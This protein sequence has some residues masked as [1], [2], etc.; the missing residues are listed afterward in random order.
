MRRIWRFL[1]LLAVSCGLPASSFAQTTLVTGQVKDLNGVPYAGATMKAGLV[2]AGT[3]VSNP[4]VTISVLSQCR[5]NGFG[6]AP[7]QVP[8]APTNGPFTLDGSGNIPGGGITLQ[9]NTLVT[10][11]GTQWSFTVNTPG[12]PPPLGNGPQTCLLTASV[13]GASQ[14]LSPSFNTCPSLALTNVEIGPGIPV[15]VI[16]SSCTPPG[17]VFLT[18]NSPPNS[19]GYYD[20]ANGVYV[21]RA[22]LPP[23]PSFSR[24][25][26]P[27]MVNVGAGATIAEAFPVN[28][29]AGNLLV[30]FCHPFFGGT[31]NS[32][33]DTAGNTWLSS[34]VSSNGLYLFYVP[35]AKAG[36]NTVTCNM[37]NSGNFANL[38][39]A[40]YAGT[41]VSGV[42]LDTTS[43]GATTGGSTTATPPALF[44]RSGELLL[45]FFTTTGASVAF[46]NFTGGFTQEQSRPQDS[47]GDN[48]A[49]V[50]GSNVATATLA[51]S[52]AW[53][54]NMWAFVPAQQV[55]QGALSYVRVAS[56]S[57]KSTVS[58]VVIT[59]NNG[60]TAGDSIFIL[61]PQFL[62][63]G[64]NKVTSV[65]DTAGNT[66]TLIDSR[67]LT[68]GNIVGWSAVYAA[69]NVIGTN[70]ANS[71]SIAFA[72]LSD[73]LEAYGVEFSGAY[74]LDSVTHANN[75][76]TNTL[77]Y[78]VTA[79]NGGE[80]LL[81]RTTYSS[82]NFSTYNSTGQSVL[83]IGGPA[84]EL[85]ASFGTSALGSNTITVST[86]EV[87]YNLGADSITLALIPSGAT[88]NNLGPVVSNGVPCTN[89]ELALSAGWQSTGSA[90]VTAAAGNGQ[91]CSWTITTGTTTAANPT[92]TDTLTNPLPNSTTVCWLNIYGG[93][94]TAVAGESLRQTTLSATAPIFTANFTPT[95]GGT[96]YFVTRGCG[97]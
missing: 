53:A 25:Q 96:T 7:C 34:G 79:Q 55:Q 8:F 80:L 49:S 62:T 23:A 47:W 84:S 89:A 90:T 52:N 17:T 16:P 65:T 88:P 26:T 36:A 15:T 21:A 63:P 1:F 54:A 64:S 97:P 10:P 31:A 58:P 4:T 2:F 42:V 41:A 3:P 13:S 83:P 78:P 45:E 75:A 37:T 32:V 56:S 22:K 18:V 48:L 85:V 5:A 57:V 20:C 61:I 69:T 60:N 38:A 59:F 33:T 19:I 39:I 68:T 87:G 9:D 29:T 70:S 71:V 77:T 14:S 82:V 93:T 50:Q 94:H 40:E 72:G 76:T 86:N 73:A 92:V 95:A 30:A 11:A 35:I 12:V 6:S 28:N 24:V 46:S 51:S 67:L 44:T 91:T 27:A 74:T 66:Y 81:T 43:L